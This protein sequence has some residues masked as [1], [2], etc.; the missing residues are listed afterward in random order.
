M[1]LYI[2]LPT[3]LQLVYWGKK[4]TPPS[5]ALSGHTS[6]L[7]WWW[8]YFWLGFVGV[9]LAVPHGSTR[10]VMTVLNVLSEILNKHATTSRE[11]AKMWWKYI[12]S[13]FIQDQMYETAHHLIH[14]FMLSDLRFLWCMDCICS[15]LMKV[16][17]CQNHMITTISLQKIWM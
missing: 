4:T 15:G 7:Y 8:I 6:W 11:E 10:V 16:L 9:L 12:H 17:G 2:F 14:F 13:Q 1:L 3:F 5:S